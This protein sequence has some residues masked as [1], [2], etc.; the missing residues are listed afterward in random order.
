[1]KFGLSDL[2]SLPD[3]EYKQIIYHLKNALWYNPLTLFDA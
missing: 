2:A 3:P 1:M